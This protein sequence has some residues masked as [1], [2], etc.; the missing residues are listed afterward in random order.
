MSSEVTH[1]ARMAMGVREW[2][3][4]AAAA[5]AVLAVLAWFFSANFSLLDIVRFDATNLLPRLD[6]GHVV[7]QTF[8]AP[9]DNLS[10]IDIS[11]ERGADSGGSVTF[12]LLEVPDPGRLPAGQPLHEESI[13]VSDIQKNGMQQFSFDPVPGSQGKAYAV[14]LTGTGDVR[15]RASSANAL[16]DADLFVDGKPADSDLSFASFHAGGAGGLLAKLSPFRPFPLRSE[17]FFVALLL[18]AAACTGW[19][20]FTIAA[21][22][23]NRCG[24]HDDGQ[25]R[26]GSAG[27]KRPRSG[28]AAGLPD[29]GAPP[30]SQT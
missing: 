9:H 17:V 11:F 7:V 27:D 25:P 19:L 4:A 24:P 13:E 2:G 12:Q 28:H 22:T 29:S 14:R 26:S 8:V 18:I 21:G 10:R 20:L 3:A 5:A 15:P 23:A 16:A 30:D 6:K 1:K